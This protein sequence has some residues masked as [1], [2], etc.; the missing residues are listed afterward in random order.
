MF[1]L[2][3]NSI[4]L[5]VFFTP[6]VTIFIYPAFLIMF[7]IEPKEPK[8]YFKYKNSIILSMIFNI[9]FIVLI[10]FQFSEES[11][12]GLY[13]TEFINVSNILS[14]IIIPINMLIR[15]IF[16][17][18]PL[19]KYEHNQKNSFTSFSKLVMDDQLFA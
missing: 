11:I 16:K 19:K 5:L 2:I 8:K 18:K 9:A 7:L 10:I 4:Q 12:S 13:F 14:L 15:K 3:S 1:D 17:S 6:F